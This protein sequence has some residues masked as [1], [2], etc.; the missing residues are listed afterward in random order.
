MRASFRGPFLPSTPGCPPILTLH[1]CRHQTR[2]ASRTG[3]VCPRDQ[4]LIG[5]Q[6]SFYGFYIEGAFDPMYLLPTNW[7]LRSLLTVLD[8]TSR[9]YVLFVIF[10]AVWTTLIPIRI[11]FWMRR[12][13]TEPAQ[14]AAAVRVRLVVLNRNLSKLF[15][16]NLILFGGCFCNQLLMGIRSEWFFR[17][18]PNM[19]VIGSFD[20]LVFLSLLGFTGLA[21][22]HCVRWFVSTK[23]EH[24]H[25]LQSR[26]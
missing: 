25:T 19:D 13:K 5:N 1:R 18:N 3:R 15:S 10:A 11:A 20:G 24:E 26:I 21:L 4:I 9:L 14:A 8:S 16:L 2:I 6:R 7:D 17:C 12:G 22:I 23:I